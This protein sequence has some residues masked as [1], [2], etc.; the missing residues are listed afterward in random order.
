MAISKVGG[1]SNGERQDAP[2]KTVHCSGTPYE[3]GL[4][5]GCQ[6]APEIHRNVELYTAYFRTRS[7]VSWEDAR[8][9]AVKDYLPNLEEIYPEIIEEMKGIAD[10]AKLTLEDIL[11]LNL[12]SEILLTAYAD[13]CTSLSQ[14]TN[15]GTM[16][17]SENWDWMYEVRETVVFLRVTGAGSGT[18]TIHMLTEA[19]IVGKI[20]MNSAGVGICMNAIRCT[21]KDPARMPVH[22]MMRRILQYAHSFDEAKSILNK[23]G[24]ASSVNFMIAD[25]NGHFGDFECTPIEIFLIQPL[26]SPEGPFITHTNHLY[27]DV[28][29]RVKDSPAK[30][31]FTRQS[32]IIELTLT[33]GEKGV[34]AS[35]DSIRARLS[36]EQGYP[37]SICRG[38]P[39]ESMEAH[40][41]LAC[42]MMDLTSGKARF[43]LGRPCEDIPIVEFGL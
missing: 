17:L 32:R 6:A 39:D 2:V 37:L 20:G 27:S 26:P 8:K 28:R 16:V 38:R 22:I 43:L 3:I 11:A 21:I 5:H 33:D 19:G 23:Y 15:S 9:T 24:L 13:G 31:S 18:M 7:G 30:H 36:D 29:N 42:C 34:E 41:T 1:Q 25:K 10:G 14:R 35:F 12:R 40:P 4:A